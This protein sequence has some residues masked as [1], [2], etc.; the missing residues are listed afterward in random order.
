[1]T[2]RHSPG[3]PNCS[4]NRVYSPPAPATP[5]AG[6]FKILDAQDVNG[7]LVMK[8]EYPNC[9][10]CSYEGV[11]IM[12]FVHCTALDALRWTMIDP[13]FR[14]PS[15]SDVAHRAP[16][17]AARF[18]ASEEGWNDALCYAR[19]WQTQTPWKPA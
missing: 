18:P 14:E 15:T 17:P 11:K 2:C 19:D 16:S 4:K 7:H 10:K 1:M 3:D 12:V 5:D 13:H 6:K 8:V 9:R